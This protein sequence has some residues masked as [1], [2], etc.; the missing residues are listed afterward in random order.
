MKTEIYEALDTRGDY[1]KIV[2][3]IKICN[4]QGDQ[5]DDYCL[6]IHTD[7]EGR[8]YYLLANPNDEYGLFIDKLKDA[9]ECIKDDIADAIIIG[10]GNERV[11]VIRYINREYGENLRQKSIKKWQNVKFAYAVKFDTICSFSGGYLVSKDKSLC[12]SS[13]DDPLEFDTKEEA[14]FFINE[15]NKIAKGFYNEYII[16]EKKLKEAVSSQRDQVLAD[17]TSI[18]LQMKTLFEKIERK[19]KI[20]WEV[21]HALSVNA[22]MN[23]THKLKAVQVAAKN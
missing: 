23:I 18:R 9:V 12:N 4:D 11:D 13:E 16:L 5:I 6:C 20:Y 1:S 17:R 21:F 10:R 7:T 2:K 14:E 15:V 8:E 3:K 22:D 19:G